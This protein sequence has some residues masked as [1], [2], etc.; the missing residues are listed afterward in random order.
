MARDSQLIGCPL[1]CKLTRRGTGGGLNHEL[2]P[3]FGGNLATGDVSVASAVVVLIG[4]EQF[5]DGGY[6]CPELL[7]GGVVHVPDL[8]ALNAGVANPDRRG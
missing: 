4:T 8:T 7:V 1:G 2:M 5:F 6:V 3:Q